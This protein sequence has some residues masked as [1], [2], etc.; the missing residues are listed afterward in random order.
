[1]E[2]AHGDESGKKKVVKKSRKKKGKTKEDEFALSF[3]DDT[4]DNEGAEDGSDETGP[5][6]ERFFSTARA[7]QITRY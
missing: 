4:V 1:M 3:F 7:S 2:K 5:P 6:F